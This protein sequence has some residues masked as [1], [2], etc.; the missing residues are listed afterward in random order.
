MVKITA[1][2]NEP[3]PV[4]ADL[5]VIVDNV[6]GTAVSKKATLDKIVAVYDS[7]TATMTN[8]TLTSPVLT[9]PNLGTPSALTL[10]SATGLPLAGVTSLVSSLALKAALASPTFSG[11]VTMPFAILKSGGM[12]G[13]GG[14]TIIP[15]GTNAI[16]NVMINPSGTGTRAQITTTRNSDPS[17]NA[18]MLT[19]G[20]DIY[21]ANEHAIR[22]YAAGT[23]TVHPLVF[24][25]NTSKVMQ[26]SS[27]T[28][29][30]ILGNDLDNIQNLVHDTSTTGVALDFNA[31]QLQLISIAA[32]TTFTTTNRAIGR[33]KTIKIV[34]DATERSLVFPAWKFVGTKPEAQVASKT[35]IL[36]ITC[37]GSA[38][39]DI[40][41][42]YAVEV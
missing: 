21:S 13:L 5:V 8:K 36:T 25:H 30:D 3:T 11:N 38:D 37:F 33:S 26:I 42:A 4:A 29:L 40:V 23:G 14:L 27:G 24:I 16:N 35:G 28:S 9:T 2:T 18:D 34:T 7:Q 20:S 32:T 10:T 6:A 12:P 17:T 15:S 19:I 22:V 31:D 41:A 1:L 39:T